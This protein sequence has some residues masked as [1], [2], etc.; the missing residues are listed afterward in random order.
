MFAPCPFACL[1]PHYM[2]SAMRTGLCL[3]HHGVPGTQH[4]GSVSVA[5]GTPNTEWEH[6]NT[7]MEPVLQMAHADTLSSASQGLYRVDPPSGNQPIWLLGRQALSGSPQPLQ[8]A[9]LPVRTVCVPG[10]PLRL[11]CV[12]WQDPVISEKEQEFGQWKNTL[13]GGEGNLAMGEGSYPYLFPTTHIRLPS[14]WATVLP[15]AYSLHRKVSLSPLSLDKQAP[16]SSST[17]ILN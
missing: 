13:P 8:L 16:V 14:G 15:V 4:K 1:S 6:S 17:I 5:S 2:V 3:I 10:T 7:R 12:Q 11:A 9:D